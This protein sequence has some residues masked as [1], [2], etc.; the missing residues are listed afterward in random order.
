[1]IHIICDDV[2]HLVVAAAAAGGTLGHFLKFLKGFLHI[3]KAMAVMQGVH[4]IKVADLLAV[5]NHSVFH[6]FSSQRLYSL[7]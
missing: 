1:M 5:A 4:D 7:S 3:L 2:H 6:V